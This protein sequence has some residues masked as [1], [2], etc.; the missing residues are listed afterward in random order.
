M[1]VLTVLNSTCCR[2]IKMPWLFSTPLL[3]AAQPHYNRCPNGAASAAITAVQR[4]WVKARQKGIIA[5]QATD[6][7]LPQHKEITHE[8]LMERAKLHWER[9][10]V[11][12]KEF[13][14]G[15]EL[16]R[17][18]DNFGLAAFLLHQSVE[19]TLK[20]LIQAI[21]GYRVQMHN[22]SKLLR[23]ALLFTDDLKSV[24][25]LDTTEGEQMFTLLQTSY[26]QSRYSNEFNPDGKSVLALSKT[27]KKMIT[28]AGKIYLQ[29][30]G[31]KGKDV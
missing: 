22:L 11:Q 8:L 24:F 25:N 15:A 31:K 12:G 6:F 29:Y 20:A 19:G 5:Y 7:E 10:G 23:I 3:I 2:L 13:F 14:S 9:W 1:T 21:L 18:Q 16:Y 27:V 17:C 30:A 4:F 26:S 28:V